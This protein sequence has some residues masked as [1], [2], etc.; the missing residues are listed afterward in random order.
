MDNM[1]FTEYAVTLQKQITALAY[2]PYRDARRIRRLKVKIAQGRY[3][4]DPARVADKLI[5][6]ERFL[7]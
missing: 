2:T 1:K 3:T 7:S 6:L 4:P 5:A